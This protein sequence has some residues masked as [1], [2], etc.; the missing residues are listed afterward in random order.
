[1]FWPQ[2]DKRINGQIC[3]NRFDPFPDVFQSVCG[4]MGHND[5]PSQARILNVD[6]TCARPINSS[7]YLPL[8]PG[9]A[10]VRTKTITNN[11]I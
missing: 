4:S 7:L 8:L 2:T 10:W 6:P 5:I 3:P 11:S 1:M 9:Q